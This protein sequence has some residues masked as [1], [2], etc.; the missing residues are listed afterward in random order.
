M[1]DRCILGGPSDRVAPTVCSARG[2]AIGAVFAAVMSD[3]STLSDVLLRPR[4]GRPSRRVVVSLVGEVP[5]SVLVHWL[6]SGSRLG[7]VRTVVVGSG[8]SLGDR[9]L[10][11]RVPV[12]GVDHHRQPLAFRQQSV[13]VAA[14]AEIVVVVLLPAGPLAPVHKGHEPHVVHARGRGQAALVHGVAPA[15]HGQLEVRRAVHETD[16]LVPPVAQPGG[17]PFHGNGVVQEV[18]QTVRHVVQVHEPVLGGRDGARGVQEVDVALPADHGLLGVRPSRSAVMMVVQGV[19][20]G[21]RSWRRHFETVFVRTVIAV[22]LILPRGGSVVVVGVGVDMR[23]AG[24]AAAQPGHRVVV[25]S[26]PRPV[27]SRRRRSR[28]APRRCYP[29]RLSASPTSGL[30][31]RDVSLCRD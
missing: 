27:R 21:A 6:S 13:A 22:V 26:A 1:S 19:I 5:P 31:W 14:P 12:V 18:P 15:A 28:D 11:G 24:R 8:R 10:E 4:A 29:V 25:P 20:V 30:R 17:V 16:E 3:C 9:D 23:G 2:G 7:S